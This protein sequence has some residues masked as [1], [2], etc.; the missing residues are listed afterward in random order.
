MIYNRDGTINFEKFNRLSE[1]QQVKFME[2][3]TPQQQMEY[4][5]QNTITEEECFG[6][7]F[8]LIEEIEAEENQSQL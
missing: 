6:P 2:H 4:L 7:V 5:M 1:D 3:W 8:E